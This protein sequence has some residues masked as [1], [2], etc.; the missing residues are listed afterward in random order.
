[1]KRPCS[2]KRRFYDDSPDT[3][4]VLRAMEIFTAK[5]ND[6]ERKVDEVKTVA[7]AFHARV[8]VV[9]ML[10]MANGFAEIKQINKQMMEIKQMMAQ[11]VQ[12][13]K[14]ST[15]SLCALFNF[16]TFALDS[17]MLSANDASQRRCETPGTA[18]SSFAFQEFTDVSARVTVSVV[19][20]SASDLK[21]LTTAR[22]PCLGGAEAVFM[23]K[24][25]DRESGELWMDISRKP[26]KHERKV[27]IIRMNAQR[28]R[29]NRAR[30]APNGMALVIRWSTVAVAKGTAKGTVYTRTLSDIYFHGHGAPVCTP[31]TPSTVPSLSLCDGMG[32]VADSVSALK[33]HRSSKGKKHQKAQSDESVVLEASLARRSKK[34]KERKKK[35]RKSAPSVPSEEWTRS[36]PELEVEVGVVSECGISVLV[37]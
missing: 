11:M 37:A 3:R 35:R 9:W 5:L 12:S 26:P 23:Q 29:A 31:K 17:A 22:L 19:L 1:M 28:Q 14:K 18:V 24:L 4:G 15:Q 13:Q 32:F 6:V 33:R 25:K 8:D 21:R 16:K 27:R 10:E 36:R 30:W 20:F 34:K 2:P 7:G